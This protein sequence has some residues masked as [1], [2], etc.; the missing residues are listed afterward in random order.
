MSKE[1][2]AFGTWQTWLL[3]PSS[4]LATVLSDFASKFSPVQHGVTAA[5]IR[6]ALKGSVQGPL[7]ACTF[8][9]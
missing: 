6:G 9:K 1:R 3:I 2:M 8:I 5:S 7:G 4:P